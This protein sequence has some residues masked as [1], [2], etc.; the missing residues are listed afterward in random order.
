MTTSY[1]KDILPLFRPGDVHCMDPKG[2]RLDDAG[3]MCDPAANDDFSDHANARRVFAALTA[4]FMPPGHKWSQDT[5]DI[6]ASW[7]TDG[8]QP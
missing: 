1:G 8:F 4:G 2:V 5:L 6:Y 7:I 3:W